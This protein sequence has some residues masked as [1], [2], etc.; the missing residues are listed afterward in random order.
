MTCAIWWGMCQG[1]HAAHCSVLNS[2]HALAGTPGLK[3]VDQCRTEPAEGSP[4]P[5]AHAGTGTPQR[6]A[7]EARPTQLTRQSVL[8]VR[9]TCSS[10]PFSN[11][12]YTPL[13]AVA[14]K[15]ALLVTVHA[16]HTQARPKI[17]DRGPLQGPSSDTL[18]F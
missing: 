8:A 4:V 16:E 3:G 14:C 10:G 17:G 12:R 6:H 18:L 1:S 5:C 11:A 7:P 15:D 13:Q 2:K 9:V